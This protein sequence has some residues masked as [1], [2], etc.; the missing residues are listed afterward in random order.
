M[1]T[2]LIL[3][4]TLSSLA[5]VAAGAVLGAAPVAAHAVL[6]EADPAAGAQLD[7]P[8]TEVVLVFDGELSPETSRFVVT[9]ADGA[10]AGEGRLD[11][12]VAERNRLRGPVDA[13]APGSYTVTWSVTGD[14]GHAVEDAYTFSVRGETAG[15]GDEPEPPDTALPGA[16]DVASAIGLAL[17]AAAAPVRR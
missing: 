14:D 5:L 1:A 11:L 16:M 3:T 17:L 7:T 15:E 10:V 2:T 9:D 4:R 8:P 13:M 6:T 12:E